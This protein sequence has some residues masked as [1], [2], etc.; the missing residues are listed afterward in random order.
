MLQI[1]YTTSD[2]L[3]DDA[4]CTA[5]HVPDDTWGEVL[6]HYRCQCCGEL[7]PKLFMIHQDLWQKVT[8]G[9]TDL[10]LCWRCTES[11]L[12]RSIAPNDLTDCMLNCVEHPDMMVVNGHGFE[13]FAG[14]QGGNWS[15]AVFSA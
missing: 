10:L 2:F 15:D 13:E 12:G 6:G 8:G 1:R 9:K 7:D 5:C 3:C 4:A 14:G 11:Q